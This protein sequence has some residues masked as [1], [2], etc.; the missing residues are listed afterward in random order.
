M[1]FSKSQ[2]M[3]TMRALQKK[4]CPKSDNPNQNSGLNQLRKTLDTLRGKK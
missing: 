1:D 4:D 3:K 2:L